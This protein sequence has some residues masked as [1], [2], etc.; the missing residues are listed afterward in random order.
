MSLLDQLAAS[1]QQAGADRNTDERVAKELESIQARF[2]QAAADLQDA[3]FPNPDGR[4]RA[5]EE[6]PWYVMIGASATF[7]TAVLVSLCIKE[8]AHGD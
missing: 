4:P 5:I 1:G 6:M 2:K 3:R 8:P 7:V